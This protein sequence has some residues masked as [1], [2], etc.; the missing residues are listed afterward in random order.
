[1]EGYRCLSIIVYKTLCTLVHLHRARCVT[2][3]RSCLS[4]FPA[5]ISPLHA[6]WVIVSFRSTIRARDRIFLGRDGVAGNF[7]FFFCLFQY[8]P[9]SGFHKNSGFCFSKG[10]K[11]STAIDVCVGLSH[12]LCCFS[13]WC[14]RGRQMLIEFKR[15]NNDFDLDRKRERRFWWSFRNVTLFDWNPA[16]FLPKDLKRNM[17][18]SL[19]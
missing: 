10:A 12:I 5:R 9:L 19:R 2:A 15:P 3:N 8:L 7:S 17:L 16:V 11:R 13:L 14:K 6:S 18:R 4:E 1:M